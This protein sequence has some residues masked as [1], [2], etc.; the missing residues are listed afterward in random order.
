MNSR[1]ATLSFKTEFVLC[2]PALPEDPGWRTAEGI[3]T[4][5]PGQGWERGEPTQGRPCEKWHSR[6][7]EKWQGN[8]ENAQSLTASS[9]LSTCVC[10]SEKAVF[11]FLSWKEY[12]LVAERKKTEKGKEKEK[13]KEDFH[14]H[15]WTARSFLKSMHTCCIKG[16]PKRATVWE[17][18]LL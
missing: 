5:A 7:A 10:L 2:V 3:L 8:V 12:M 13:K 16:F 15:C 14:D 17:H 4:W 11:S 1:P 18:T 9:K 6:A